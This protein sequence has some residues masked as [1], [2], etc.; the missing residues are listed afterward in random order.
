MTGIDSAMAAKGY[1]ST[2]VEEVYQELYENIIY[3]I[4][5]LETKLLLMISLLS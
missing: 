3:L 5:E 4:R 1:S 2:M